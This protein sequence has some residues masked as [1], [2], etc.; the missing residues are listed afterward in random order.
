MNHRIVLSLLLAAL[1]AAP[2]AAG[3]LLIPLAAGT[4]PDGT[5]YAT[6][7]WITNTGAVARSLTYTFIAPG[8]DGTQVRANGNLS[9]PAGDTVLAQ[10]LAPAG[11]SGLL[12]VNGAPQLLITPRLEAVRP[13]GAL[14]AAAAGP[15]VS[16]LQVAS[17]NSTLHLHGLSHRQGGLITDLHVINASR[18]PAQCAVDAFRDN[19]S[20]IGTTLRFNLPPLSSRVIENAVAS[21]GAGGIDESRLA[22]SCGQPFYA[23]AR[24]AKPGSAE[25]NVVTPAP[26]LG[27]D[28]ATAAGASR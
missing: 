5:A 1:F 8:A 7:I 16:G 3:E 6:R 22:I 21:F 26:A 2:L 20:R 4:A 25:L 15:V 11:R 28:V 12:L 14:R 13:N 19:G 27:R 23:W 18:Q 10:N 9:I 17:G 24:V